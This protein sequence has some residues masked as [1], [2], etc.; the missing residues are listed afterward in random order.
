[1]LAWVVEFL[2]GFLGPKSFFGRLLE[3]IGLNFVTT[4]WAAYLIGLAATLTLIYF[5][6]VLVE[7]GMKNR[8]HALIDGVMQRLPLVRTIYN[9]AKRLIGMLGRQDNADLKTMSPVICHFGGAGGT[10]VLAL[11]PSSEVI[12]IN[13]RDHHAVMIPTA[14]VPFG[15][16]LLFLPVEW[17]EP[18]NFAVDGL[19]DVYMSMGVTS[20]DYLN[21]GPLERADRA[22]QTPQ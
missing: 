7:A 21:L 9:A 2:R 11:M 13:G 14:P 19:V 22:D 15:G 10:A 8:W 1:M 3:K 12:S 5:L 17:V 20:A 4:N 18:A 6:G 16:A